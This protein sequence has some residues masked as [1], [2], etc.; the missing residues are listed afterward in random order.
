MGCSLPELAVAWTLAWP[1]V[2]A[3]IVGARAAAQVDGWI[4]G[5]RVALADKDL[6]D[7]ATAVAETAAGD[8]PTR[9]SGSGTG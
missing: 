6:D 9:P 2:T 1:G 8:G 3:A 7:I 5:A 4:G